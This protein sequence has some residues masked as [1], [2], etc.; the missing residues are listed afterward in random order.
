M[1]R[2]DLALLYSINMMSV[3]VYS[4]SSSDDEKS[5]YEGE[6]EEEKIGFL[7]FRVTHLFEWVKTLKKRVNELEDKLSGQRKCM[8]YKFGKRHL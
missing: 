6:S 3:S 7:E 8:E 2:E 1:I 5:E 4:S